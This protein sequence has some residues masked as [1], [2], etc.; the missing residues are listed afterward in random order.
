MSQ[1]LDYL[2]SAYKVAR[3]LPMLLAI[4]CTSRTD[5]SFV[6]LE[7]GQEQR[8]C[9]ASHA[10]D[11]ALASIVHIIVAGPPGVPTALG[12]GFAVADSA[13]ADGLPR[14][15]TAAHLVASALEAPGQAAIQIVMADGRVVGQGRVLATAQPWNPALRDDPSVRDLAVL[16]LA[17][18]NPEMAQHW[19]QVAGLRLARHQ[20][21]DS[22]LRARFANPAGPDL[23]ASGSPLMDGEGLVRGVLTKV[24]APDPTAVSLHVPDIG[25]VMAGDGSGQFG[26]LPRQTIALADPVSASPVLAAL[27]TAGE[28]IVTLPVIGR[29]HLLPA[30]TAGFPRRLCVRFQGE[31]IETALPPNAASVERVRRA[32]AA[33]H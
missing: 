25:R 33:N 7:T 19:R 10:A 14:I 9:F 26:R 27:N 21:A 29:G 17:P 30:V 28:G 16:A 11:P 18:A 12:T 22:L 1:I 31:M 2:S 3:M 13:G 32:L 24:Q 23:G 4:S 6:G 8:S 20:R 15:L 5:P